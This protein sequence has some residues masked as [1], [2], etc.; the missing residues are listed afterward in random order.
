MKI[1]CV[2]FHKTGTCSLEKAL[3]I[4]GYRATGPNLELLSAIR[5]DNLQPV[6]QLVENFDAFLDDPWFLFYRELDERFPQSKFILTERNSDKW[7]RS[8]QNHFG[9]GVSPMREFI[10]GPIGSYQD[11]RRYC[12]VY[13]RH[14]EDVKRY[15][16]GRNNFIILNLENGDGWEKLCTF[17]GKTFPKSFLFKRPLPFPHA[18]SA[19]SREYLRKH[20]TFNH[21]R[22]T[23]KKQI[24][25][26]FGEQAL[27]LMIKI[28]DFFLYRFRI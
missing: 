18:N 19:S 11:P 5:T 2:G 26:T 4:L 9:D 20:P 14:N 16:A 8:V 22:R 1:F 27:R 23:L 10:Y 21:A 13:D 15:F 28:K 6:F 25:N 7:L 12:Q 24:S 17:L 3:E